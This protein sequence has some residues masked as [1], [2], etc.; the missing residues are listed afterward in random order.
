MSEPIK[1]DRRHFLSTSIMSLAAAH[2]GLFGCAS[3]SAS[4][5][6]PTEP[7]TSKDNGAVQQIT[8]VASH[9]P[10]EGELPSL[11]GATEWL[12]SQP[13]TAAGLRGKVVLV[14]FL[15]YTCIN[16]LRTLP[17][18]RTWAEKYKDHGLVVIGVHAPEFTFEQELDNVRRAADRVAGRL[19]RS[20]STVTSRSGGRSE[21][22]LAGPL[23][24]RCEG[25]GPTPPVRRG[26]VR[27][28]GDGFSAVAGRGRSRR[29]RP[30]AGLG[31]GAGR[32]GCSPI[33]QPEVSRE[34]CR[35]R[36]YRELC[37]ARRS[38]GQSSGLCCPCA[39]EAQSVGSRG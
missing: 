29:H 35:L 4:K 24:R 33:A 32:R 16:W 39:V 9:L 38:H 27:A 14:E 12:N 23:L 22:L 13:L 28:V 21:P 25:A 20:R 37:V 2:L 36:A 6:E 26:Q 17:Y 7:S 3:V 8:P 18:V 31:R 15:T 30:G 1:R 19:T 10:V 11:G 34:L 5:T